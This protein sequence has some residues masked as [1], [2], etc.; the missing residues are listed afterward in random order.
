[1]GRFP[2][3][4]GLL[5]TGLVGARVAAADGGSGCGEVTV[6]GCCQ[7][8]VLYYCFAGQLQQQ[9]CSGSPSC[10]WDP[11]LNFY[12]CS[13]GGGDDPSGK[14]PRICPGLGD[15]GLVDAA[16]GDAQPSILDPPVV[17]IPDAAPPVDAPSVADSQAD[18][19]GLDRT[20]NGEVEGGGC[21][22]TLSPRQAP[23]G[24]VLLLLLGLVR[25]RGGAS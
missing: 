23:V 14:H 25:R 20:E 13:T 17:P 1:M 2:A 6:K 21:G 7:T 4:V 18:R 12:A 3:L 15:G 10:G 9:D 22:C 5:V 8:G 11:A 19:A 24:A 16:P